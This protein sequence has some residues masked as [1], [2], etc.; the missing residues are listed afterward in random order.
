M[1]LEASHS[2]VFSIRIRLLCGAALFLLFLLAGP[3]S[4]QKPPPDLNLVQLD[5]YASH[6]SI[7]PGQ[8][9]QLSIVAIIQEG[10]HINSHKPLN[11]FLVPTVVTFDE[12]DGIVFGPLSYPV[13]AIK[14]FSFSRNKV[15]VYEGRIV[16]S[17]RARL[18]ENIAP[19]RI[20]ISGRLAYQACNDQ[21][22]F[23]PRSVKFAVPLQ[24]VEPSQPIKLTEKDVFQQEPPLTPDELHAR[25][26][27]ESG[28]PY[29]L[30]AFFIFGL[31]LNLTPC[32]YPIIPIT[33]SFFV[34]QKERRSWGAFLL[35]LYYVIGIAVVFS[36]LGL[37][38]GLAG[39]QWGF[40]FQSPW[41]I[42]VITIIILSMA[43]SMFGAFEITIPSFLMTPL[44]K[45][46]QGPIGSLVMGLTVGVV[47][48][49]C[50]AGILI[51]LVGIVAK[52]GIVAKG[53]VLFFVMGL[54]LGLPYL[55]LATFSGL[56]NRMPKSGMWMVWIRKLFGL[57][58]IGVAIYFLLP[59]AGQA[60]NQ[61]GFY[62]GVLAIFGGVFLG[63]LEHGEGY[64]Q[65]FKKIRALIGMVLIISGTWMVNAA[66]QPEKAAIDWVDHRTRSIDSYH[67]SDRPVIMEF[68][69]D[70]CAACKV[71]DDQT[72]KD[73]RVVEKSRAFVMVRV[74]C[75]SPDDKSTALT[76][77][78]KIS[79]LPTV[80]FIG[81]GGQELNGLRIVGHLG[82]ADMLEKMERALAK[83]TGGSQ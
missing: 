2:R 33:V 24:I 25:R 53:T 44:G 48:A 54:G 82:P 11:H 66:I 31:A 8:P 5:A 70:W 81:A 75:T 7:H 51:G 62:L 64:T 38:S 15:S 30:I 4:G 78:F 13:P 10:F 71:L 57:L 16:I 65:T 50:A 19:A 28:L 35:A 77:R 49:P 14:S 26:I 69:A 40:L 3:S 45:S 68:Y 63:F 61:Q 29:A 60:A 58:L 20:K 39:K 73:P 18:A 59:Q 76:E 56:L 52:L 6:E 80:L 27:I 47:I 21:S 32:V 79:G 1:W 9:L 83:P 22:C 46:R 67:I 12:T 74:D 37:I 55:F 72:F 36:A 17:T 41:F 43:A 23:M 34:A 42:I